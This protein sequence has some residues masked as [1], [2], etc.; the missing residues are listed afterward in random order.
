MDLKTYTDKHGQ[1]ALA[2]RIGVAPSFMSQWVNGHR[3]IPVHFCL[4]IE[5]AT[6]G[7]VRR[8]ELCAGWRKVWPDLPELPPTPSDSPPPASAQAALL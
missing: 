4:P 8:Q 3:P 7:Q 2:D 5:L 1:K 6:N